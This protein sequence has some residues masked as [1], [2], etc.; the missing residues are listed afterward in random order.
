MD[1]FV[2]VRKEPDVQELR[3]WQ[4]EWRAENGNIY[5]MVDHFWDNQMPEEERS[6][7]DLTPRSNSPATARLNQGEINT[8]QSDTS[9]TLSYAVP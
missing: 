1:T 9:T 8:T 5:A 2:Q 3:Q 4:Q 7:R 6:A